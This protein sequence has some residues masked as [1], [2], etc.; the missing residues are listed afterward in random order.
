MNILLTNDDG[1]HAEGLQILRQALVRRGHQ[2]RIAAPDRERSAASQSLTITRPLR[3]RTLEPGVY[4]ID[5]TPADCVHLALL[6]LV[7]EW[8][9]LV[10]SGINWGLNVGDNIYYSGTVAAAAEALHLGLPAV[11]LSSERWQPGERWIHRSADY[12]VTLAEWWQEQ[13]NWRDKC[14][15]NV[16]FPGEE[17]RAAR[18]TLQ[19]SRDRHSKAVADTDPMGRSF[20]W[21]WSNNDGLRSDPDADFQA[22]KEGMVALTPLRIERT[23][24]EALNAL[25]DTPL[26]GT[27]PAGEG[28]DAD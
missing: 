9:E 14:L 19:G 8:A 1:I 18:L 28:E 25:N 24:L 7:A 11:A 15:L 5:G 16:N 6:N 10:I 27:P 20:Y 21:A 3:V 4:S 26:P 23:H 22:V 13:P 2:V 17:F 12:A